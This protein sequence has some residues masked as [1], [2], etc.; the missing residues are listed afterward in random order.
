MR[1]S[2][3]LRVCPLWDAAPAELLQR[4][5]ERSFQSRQLAADRAAEDQF[6][7]RVARNLAL[8]GV[9]RARIA[10]GEAERASFAQFCRRQAP[11]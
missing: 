6:H 3:T 11:R 8:R 5:K 7:A 2:V 1:R 9:R 4:A 10:L